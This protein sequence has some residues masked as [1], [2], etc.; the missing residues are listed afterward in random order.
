MREEERTVQAAVTP[1]DS[2]GEMVYG[3]DMSQNTVEVSARLCYVKEVAL[4]IEITGQPPGAL[5]VT[6]KEVPDKLFI[7]GA[8]SALEGVD[9]VTADPIDISNLRSTTII[10]PQLGLPEGVETADAS[11][12]I[13]VTI[14]IGGEEAKSFTV[15][16]AETIEVKNAPDGYSVHV[17]TGTLNV[18][19]YGSHG[20]IEDFSLDKLKLFVDLNGVDPAQVQVKVLIG[21]EDTDAFK[22]ADISPIAADVRIVALPETDVLP[23]N[24]P[25]SGTSEAAVK[26]GR[27]IV[28]GI[29]E[30]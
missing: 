30:G 5:A 13:A 29:I 10:T 21:Y 7:R 4:D 27:S 22:R 14:E 19:I 18:T 23:E 8:K 6:K 12:D 16:A 17:V 11:R 20:Q 9:K 25:D 1:V 15:A 24:L 2:G 28:S 26:S 3:V